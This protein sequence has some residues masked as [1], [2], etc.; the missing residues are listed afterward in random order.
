MTAN[1]TDA[2]SAYRSAARTALGIPA[3]ETADAAAPKPGQSFA[4]L[5]KGTVQDAVQANK[6]AEQMS[7]KALTG[8]ADLR[9][10]V[11]AV[12][13]AEVTLETVVAIRDK[14][15]GAYNEILKMPM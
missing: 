10:V 2:I 6:K 1:F 4:A 3:T 13:N 14:V 7:M 8:Q 11:T 12:A 15:V 5:V 9:E